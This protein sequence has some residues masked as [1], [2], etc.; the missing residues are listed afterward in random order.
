M[1]KSCF[2]C[3]TVVTA[4]LSGCVRENTATIPDGVYREPAGVG[5]VT[6]QGR[7]VTLQLDVTKGLRLG[8]QSGR[9]EYELMDD[10]QVALN[11]SSND[12]F[13]LFAVVGYEWRWDGKNVIRKQKQS[14]EATVFSRDV[15]K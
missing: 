15:K 4:F 10:G 2:L 8:V 5:T 12:E 13:F 6:V 1:K 7:N 14:G 11:G 3:L 9:Y